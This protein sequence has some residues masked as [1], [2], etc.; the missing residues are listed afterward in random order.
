MLF[1]VSVYNSLV[2]DVVHDQRWDFHQVSVLKQ[3][4]TS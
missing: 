3:V 2:E 4:T 1:V